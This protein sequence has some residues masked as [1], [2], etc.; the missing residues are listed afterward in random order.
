MNASHRFGVALAASAAPELVSS[1]AS[2]CLWATRRPRL[3]SCLCPHPAL[4]APADAPL[5]LTARCNHRTV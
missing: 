3:T 2:L 5:V 1:F 4:A